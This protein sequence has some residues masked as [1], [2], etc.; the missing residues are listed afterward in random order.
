[1]AAKL[2]KTLVT[3]A[4]LAGLTAGTYN[5]L[6][7][8]PQP[9]KSGTLHIQ[10]L[11]EPVEIITDTYG[12]PHIYAQT[13]DDLFFAQGYIHAQERLWQMELNRRLGSGRLSELFG[14]MLLE[15]DRFCRR[16]GMHRSAEAEVKRL[17]ASHLRI[18]DA[19]ARGINIF[20]AFNE[21]K[22][23]VEFTLLRF[24]PDPWKPA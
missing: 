8:R 6:T 18:L 16:L 17:P 12:I 11:H 10:G 24:Q 5:L 23:P 7:H 4:N 3:A 21:G 14:D 9:Q 1:M 13:E 22:L 15:T 19:Y 2:K 20:I